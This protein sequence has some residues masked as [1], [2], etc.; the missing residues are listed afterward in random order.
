MKYQ[1]RKVK[2]LLI[3]LLR[4]EDSSHSISLGFTLGLLV[5]FVPSFGLGPIIS[6]GLARLFRGNSIAGFIGGI[7]II[8]AFPLLFYLN[9]VV[10]DLVLPYELHEQLNTLNDTTDALLAGLH[11]GKSFIVGMFINMLITGIIVYFSCFALLK[12]YRKQL[13]FYLQKKWKI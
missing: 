3:K 13:L 8:W 2:Y 9:I 12:R 1:Q 11:V 6:T 5:N 7:C 4:L 10:G